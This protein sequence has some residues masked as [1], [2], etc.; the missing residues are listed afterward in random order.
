VTTDEVIGRRGEGS[1]GSVRQRL[2]AIP[3]AHW[4]LFAIL[5]LVVVVHGWRALL[6]FYIRGDLLYHW[7][8]THTILLGA[9]PPEGPYPGLPAYYPP[10]FHVL[11]AGLAQLPGLDVQ[12]AT[13]LLGI[14]WLPVIPLGAYLLAR[15]I[16]GR[17][18]VALIAAAL[19]AFGGGFDVSLDRLWVNSLSMAGQ[20]AYPI[21]PR[22]LVFGLLPY[23]MLAFIRA[24]DGG[25]RWLGWAA[26]TGVLLGVCGLIQVQLLLP[27]PFALATYALA[28][29][30]RSRS[31]WQAFG[32]LVMAGLVAAVFVT[33]WL[34]FIA[35][36]IARNGGVSIESSE[37]LLPVR[38]GFWNYP[39]Q[40]GI[41]LPLAIAGVGLVL[42]LLRR[43][44][45]LPAAV[46]ERWSRRTATGGALL[47]AWWAVPFAL[48][49][50][51]QPTWP[52]EDAVRPQRM[53]LLASQPGLILAAMGLVAFV[54]ALAAR[55]SSVFVPAIRR[56]VAVFAA[57]VLIASLPTTVA[58][59]RLMTFLWVEPRY[60]HLQ[61]DRDHVPDMAGLLDVRAPRPT[62]LTYEDW[63]S[64]VWYETGAAVVAVEPPGYAKLA[65]DPERF[66][67]ASQAQRRT[68]LATAL[69]GDV[70]R[71]VAT[72]DR[73]DADRIVLA[74]RDGAL[75]LFGQPA[76]LSAALGA[77][78][79]P[80]T[81]VQG[82]GFDT[83]VLEPGSSLTL[84]IAD[85][86]GPIDL[87]L[88]AAF[89]GV[90]ASGGTATAGRLWVLVGDAS[91][92]E[93]SV[94][95]LPEVELSVVATSID[96][97]AGASITVEAVDRIILQ[98]VTAFV[99]DPGPPSGWTIAAETTDA[100]VWQRTP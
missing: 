94:P 47:V 70:V 8:L 6:P 60:A 53:W 27:I 3:R 11:L 40:F 22:D 73:Y 45:D 58:T 85:V 52:L 95:A 86:G 41:V 46:T 68:D 79:G 92:I 67:G 36:T 88:R 48:A 24:V 61:L 62:V 38:I 43:R 7:G 82:N 4:V 72:A 99:T 66:T 18:D 23:A 89:E 17:T 90:T 78:E 30:W 13:M 83:V 29:A 14:L 63:S 10:G 35:R 93:L 15:R 97:P 1:V 20:V 87:E 71:L 76:S 37:D 5:V 56:T 28:V 39:M 34:V 19:I 59:A 84:P 65:F 51:Y 77:V 32:A 9:F 33:P 21:Y 26:L 16:T 81:V 49:V 64:L 2:A 75:G 50:A 96:R 100:V 55:R 42:L 25:R 54:E 12:S 31:P 57:V 74:R 91:P 98:G 69:S 44:A 80:T